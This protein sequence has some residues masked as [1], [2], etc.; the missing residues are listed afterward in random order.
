MG[1]IRPLTMLC[2]KCT[3]VEIEELLSEEGWV[4]HNCWEDLVFSTSQGCETCEFFMEVGKSS[5]RL[6]SDNNNKPL[7]CKVRSIYS[8]DLVEG[9]SQTWILRVLYM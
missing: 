9:A 7:R 3:N 8:M 4:H 1:N 5:L 6:P 2:Q